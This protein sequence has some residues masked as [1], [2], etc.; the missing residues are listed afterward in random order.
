[1]TNLI[2]GLI[3]LA[4]IIAGTVALVQGGLAPQAKVAD[5]VRFV[6]EDSRP[7][8]GTEMTAI[9]VGVTDGGTGISL[10][11]RN[12]GESALRVTEDWDLILAY[13]SSATSTG[14]EIVRLAFTE[15]TSLNDDEWLVEGIYFD[16]SESE[17]EEYGK[18]IL[19]PGEE[20]VI[21]AKLGT[22]ISTPSTNSLA[23]STDSGVTTSAQFT[24]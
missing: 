8:A 20:L 13:D 17:A 15:S 24:F 2:V 9:F 16:A 10:T 11:V 19:N 12:N 7:V 3:T 14:L 5:A 18:G 6:Q 21:N 1:M 23:L 22:S 4:G